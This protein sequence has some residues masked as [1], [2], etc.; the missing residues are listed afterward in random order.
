[1][2]HPLTPF[3]LSAG[4]E[5][6]IGAV[7]K[8]KARPMPVQSQT[9]RIRDLNDTFRATL[10]DGQCVTTPGICELGGSFVVEAVAATRAFDNFTPDNDPDGE[11]DFGAFRIGEHHLVWKIDYYDTTLRYGSRDPSNPE[12]TK[13]VLTIMLAD[14][15]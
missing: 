9:C 15:W 12:E 10:A 3:D 8:P 2:T 14:E 6:A 7:S 11:H 5:T 1:M 4:V 13:R